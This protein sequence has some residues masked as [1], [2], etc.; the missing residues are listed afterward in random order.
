MNTLA[1]AADSRH[2]PASGDYV[3]E[4]HPSFPEII[5]VWAPCGCYYVADKTDSFVTECAKAGCDFQWTQ[6]AMALEALR[7][8]EQ[9]PLDPVQEAPNGP[10]VVPNNHIPAD[11]NPQSTAPEVD[12]ISEM[13]SEGGPVEPE[14]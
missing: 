3:A 1:Q 2:A 8:A 11:A 7:M 14:V 5:L 6:V 12:E 10:S 4:R 9:T 13:I